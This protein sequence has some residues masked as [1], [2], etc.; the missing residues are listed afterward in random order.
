MQQKELFPVEILL[1]FNLDHEVEGR[2]VMDQPAFH[3][4]LPSWP[5]FK[6]SLGLIPD[7]HVEYRNERRFCGVA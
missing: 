7:K 5:W 1:M 6:G 4:G 3:P 2:N